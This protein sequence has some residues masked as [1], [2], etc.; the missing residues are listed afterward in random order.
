M[1]KKI[2]NVDDVHIF[3]LVKTPIMCENLCH[4]LEKIEKSVFLLLTWLCCP[5]FKWICFCSHI[6]IEN[7]YRHDVA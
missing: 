3:F 2:I 5:L 6:Q 4:N 7:I 1:T